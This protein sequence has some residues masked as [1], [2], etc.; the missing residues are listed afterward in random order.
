VEL[1]LVL[2]LGEMAFVAMWMMILIAALG[3]HL[4]S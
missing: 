2:V 1:Q 4:K 3:S